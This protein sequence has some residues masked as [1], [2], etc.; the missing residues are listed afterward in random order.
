MP[1]L[2]DLQVY[3]KNLVKKLK[4]KELEKIVIVEKSKIE[5]TEKEFNTAL[6][7][8]HLKDVY[9]VGKELYFDF[10]KDALVSMHLMLNG[11]LIQDDKE[12]RPKHTIAA[13]IFKDGNQLAM[14]D[15]QKIAKITL[16]PEP[17]DVV[18]ALSD[19]LTAVWLEGKLQKSRA[20]IKSFIIDQKMI[21]GI[22]NAYADEI[23]W[24]A[25]ISP[26]SISSKIPKEAVARLAKA[27]KDVLINAEKEI[28]KSNPDIISGEIRDFMAVHNS[29]R[30]TSPTGAEIINEKI[31]GKSTYYTDEQEL[32]S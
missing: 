3:S 27:I 21:G 23:L 30:K 26:K 24:E 31:G 9:R 14:T 18:D 1:E 10:G 28:L 32:Y 20:I 22:G 19:E 15:F 11:K 7:G 13:F 2:S 12:E 16:N 4:G 25:K 29:K 5:A 17:N 6:S 8:K